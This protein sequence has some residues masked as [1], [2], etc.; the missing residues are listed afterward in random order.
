MSYSLLSPFEEP[1]FN[2]GVVKPFQCLGVGWRLVK[3][4]YF[5]YVLL[6][7][8]IL[9]ILTCIPF[10]GLFW[11]AWM[12]GI[13]AA[14]FG[15][16]RGEWA[17]FSNTI[18]KGFGV[19][20]PSF[21]VAILWNLPFVPLGIGIELFSRWQDQIQKTYPGATPVPSDVLTTEFA[22]LGGLLVFYVLAFLITGLIFPFAYQLVVDRQMSGW[23]AVK[24]SARAARAN[25]GGVLGLVILDLI[26]VA[27]GIALCCVGLPFILPLTKGAWAI[28][29]TEVFSLAPQNQPVAPPYPPPPPPPPPPA[30]GS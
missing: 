28:A 22:A 26:L 11:G 7:L 18:S 12:S 19:V 13:Y 10:S 21:M 30:F 6:C 4:Q 29:Y 15:R 5:V 20:G 23:K 8:V 16:M 1:A 3:D 27:V 25:F 2:S 17:S 14:L 24:L 9:I